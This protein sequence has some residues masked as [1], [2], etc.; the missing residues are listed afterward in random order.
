M[1]KKEF[2]SFGYDRVRERYKLFGT[3]YRELD[4]EMHSL[5]KDLNEEQMNRVCNRLIDGIRP[6]L[7]DNSAIVRVVNEEKK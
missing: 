4:C 1:N 3:E 6:N 5:M 7:T 2:Y